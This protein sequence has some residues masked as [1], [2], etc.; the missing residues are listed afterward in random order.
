MGCSAADHYARQRVAPLECEASD[1]H[2]MTESQREIGRVPYGGLVD[3]PREARAPKIAGL[4]GLRSIA[5]V[6]VLLRHLVIGGDANRG[7]RSAFIKLADAG[8]IGVDL[9]FV[10]SGFLITGILLRSKGRRHKFRNFYARRSLRIFPLY[11]FA[12]CVVFLLAPLFGC[13][14]V[15]FRDQLSFWAYVA[16]FRANDAAAQ[17]LNI[18]HFWSLAIEEQYYAIWPAVVL[19]TSRRT[20]QRTCL[21]LLVVGAVFRFSVFMSGS[22]GRLY[23]WTFA[24]MDGLVCG[25]LLA[26]TWD[27][28]V[29][30]HRLMRW[31]WP[32]LL[33]TGSSVGALVWTDSLDLT[34]SSARSLF[35]ATV[36]I[37]VPLLLAVFFSCVLVIV[38]SGG[39]LTD[40]LENAFTRT[41]ARFS[42]GV[43]VWHL[44]LLNMLLVSLSPIGIWPR[45]AVIA[46]ASFAVAIVSYY[47]LERPAL[48]LKARFPQAVD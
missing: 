26:L 10:L 11:Y 39:V 48:A 28:S 31:A 30:R 17:C 16:N 20:A 25:S 6:L 18:G 45:A 32:V 35:A 7:W 33:V 24:R 8:W 5:I 23:Y 27:Y 44:I 13:V 46:A 42:Y 29:V 22:D 36:L 3:G 43:Y 14:A 9:F 38:L 15:A 4:D 41:V 34:F 37:G 19:S 47:V 2:S 12:L 40:L 21:F 1:V